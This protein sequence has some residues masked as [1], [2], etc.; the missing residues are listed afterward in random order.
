MAHVHLVIYDLRKPGQNYPDLIVRQRLDA[1][2]QIRVV[3]LRASPLT[4]ESIA[5][6]TPGPI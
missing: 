2:A 6:S 3:R 4:P 1:R 5:R